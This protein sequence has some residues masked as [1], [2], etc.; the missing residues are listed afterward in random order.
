MQAWLLRAEPSSCP[1][2]EQSQLQ[3]APKGTCCWQRGE[4]R[5]CNSNWERQ[6]RTSPEDPKVSAEGGQEVLQALRRSSPAAC[7]EAPVG[8]GCPPEAHG[9]HGGA[10]L[11]IACG[12]AHG[13]AGSLAEAA[14][15]AEHMLEQIIVKDCTLRYGSI[16]GAVLDKLLPVGIPC[17]FSSERTTS[18]GRNPMLEQG[19]RVTVKEQ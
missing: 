5:L 19:R 1:M 6:V 7:G 12:G 16:F 14:A 18:C 2:S 13:G 15:H 10:D 11:H 8:A 3:L 4:K 17:R 9:S